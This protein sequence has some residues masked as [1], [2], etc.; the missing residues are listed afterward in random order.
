MQRE[1]S[2]YLSSPNKTTFHMYSLNITALE[3]GCSTVFLQ[4]FKDTQTDKT[5]PD[6]DFLI[7]GKPTCEHAQILCCNCPDEPAELV[8]S[9]IRTCNHRVFMPVKKNADCRW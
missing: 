1:N 4:V 8:Q 7:V 3:S 6:S 9:L 5:V 2:P